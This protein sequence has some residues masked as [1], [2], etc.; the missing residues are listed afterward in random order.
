MNTKELTA[1][2][3]RVAGALSG[4]GI[5]LE[6]LAILVGLVLIIAGLAATGTYG[7]SAPSASLVVS[8]FAVLLS[9]VWIYALFGF[10]EYVLRLLGAIVE[11]NTMLLPTDADFENHVATAPLDSLK[12]AMR[13]VS[14]TQQ[15]L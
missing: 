11:T 4:I 12:A 6:C 8:G 5:A 13:E 10:L 7:E 2:A 1:K 15:K 3:N 14:K 9:T